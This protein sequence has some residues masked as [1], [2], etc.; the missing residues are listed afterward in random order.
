MNHSQ[1]CDILGVKDAT[2][3]DLIRKNFEKLEQDI[4]RQIEATGSKF[5]RESLRKNKKAVKEAYHLLLNDVS[6]DGALSFGEAYKLF[7][8]RGDNSPASLKAAFEKLKEDYSFGLRSPN[9]TIRTLAENDLKILTEVFEQL[10]SQVEPDKSDKIDQADAENLTNAVKEKVGRE[11]NE[12]IEML[13]LK[14]DKTIKSFDGKITD[15]TSENNSLRKDILELLTALADGYTELTVQTAQALAEKYGVKDFKKQPT[16]FRQKPKVISVI[17]PTKMVKEEINGFGLEEINIE[18]ADDQIDKMMI[19]QS[20]IIDNKKNQ[21]ADRSFRSEDGPLSSRSVA[22]KLFSDGSYQEALLYF[23]EAKKE[24]P[25]DHSLD[26]YI[27]EIEQLVSSESVTEKGIT[28]NGKENYEKEAYEEILKQ[29]NQLRSEKKFEE[30][31]EMYSALLISDSDNPYLLY[32]KSECE[33]GVKRNRVR[34]GPEP[35]QK[36]PTITE[37]LTLKSEGD[38][39]MNN[40]NYAAALEAYEKVLKINPTDMYIQIMIDQCKRELMKA[41]K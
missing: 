34:T 13:K 36:R 7:R 6:V 23:N 18:L 25:G 4:N 39:H 32:C 21:D 24:N 20:R 15:L 40:R 9:K 11:F 16:A 31:L 22:E 27:R 2:N 29:A 12:K 26:V 1:A 19:K 28:E 37:L 14:Y 38:A 10:T 5:L 30:A 17:S 3:A 8:D 35:Q 33:D 41:E